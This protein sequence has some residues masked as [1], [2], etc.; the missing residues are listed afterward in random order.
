M[1]TLSLGYDLLVMLLWFE[2]E[3][4]FYDH[5]PILAMIQP[6]VVDRILVVPREY[7]VVSLHFDLKVVLSVA[8]LERP[9]ELEDRVAVYLFAVD[10]LHILAL[11]HQR[12]AS[13]HR[14]SVLDELDAE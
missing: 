8:R 2:I 5:S 11:I 1:C 9:F 4:H 3:Q 12:F 14:M 10:Q 6:F 7:Q 13:R